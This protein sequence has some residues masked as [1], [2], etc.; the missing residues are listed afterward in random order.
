MVAVAA[1]LWMAYLMPTWSRRRQYLA[2]ERNAVRLQQTLRILAETAEV[3][4]QVRLEAN[5]RTVAAQQKLLAQAEDEAR[6]EEKKAADAAAAV[7]R[8]AAAVEAAARPPVVV[9]PAASLRRLRRSRALCSLILMLGVVSAIVGIVPVVASGSWILLGVGVVTAVGAFGTL[10]RLAGV[11]RAARMV[12]SVPAPVATVAPVAQPFEPVHLETTPVAP[13][14]WTPR[15]L[16]RP[17]HLSRGSIA[18]AAMASVEAAAQLRKAATEADLAR[19]ASEL[20]APV[21]PISRPAVARATAGP[22]AAA[23]APPNRF[24]AMG[25]VGE[26]APGMTDLDAV[27]R[28]RRAVG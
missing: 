11:A 27:L 3:P 18:Q 28:R 12:V 6:A 5:A 16:P 1:V 22:T 9:S 13:P 15:P 2:T 20:A 7:R 19:R 17:L 10:S 8:A 21:T 4:E 26:T 24:A 23:A 14:I 25:I